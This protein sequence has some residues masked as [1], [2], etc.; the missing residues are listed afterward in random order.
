MNLRSQKQLAARVMNCGIT[1]VRIK[2]EKEVEE[3]ITRE[4]IRNLIKKGLI[5]K[6]QKKGQNRAMARKRL[7]QKK[8]GRKKGFGSRKGKAG[9]R[10]PKKTRWM[11]TIRSVRKALK[12][13]KETG[14]I[15]SGIYRKLYLRA[16]GGTFKSRRHLILYLKG[17]ELLKEKPIRKPKKKTKPIKAAKKTVKKPTAKKPAAKKPKARKVMATKRGSK[18]VKK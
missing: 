15:E 9:S 2:T 4:D 12:N 10:N 3:A 8:R 6:V 5:W 17:H 13:L 18:K 7:S 14:A 16:K 11:K 1:R